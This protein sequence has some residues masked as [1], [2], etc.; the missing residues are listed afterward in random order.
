MELSDIKPGTFLISRG[1]FKGDI[2]I[3]TKQLPNG[4]VVVCQLNPSSLNQHKQEKLLEKFE[5]ISEEEALRSL[6]G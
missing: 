2:Y 3:I 1:W 6:G 5:K 4:D